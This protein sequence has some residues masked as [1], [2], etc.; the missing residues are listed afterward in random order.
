MVLSITCGHVSTHMTNSLS[1]LTCV[2]LVLFNSTSST[3]PRSHAEHCHH[4]KLLCYSRSLGKAW[5]SLIKLSYYFC[6]RAQLFLLGLFPWFLGDPLLSQPSPLLFLFLFMFSL[7]SMVYHFSSNI[8]LLILS[9]WQNF[10]PGWTNFFTFHFIAAYYCLRKLGI[11][12][13]WYHF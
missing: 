5:D 12:I 6:L 13:Y 1:S 4:E 7:D 9:V 2:F 10:K 3:L 8:A 11:S